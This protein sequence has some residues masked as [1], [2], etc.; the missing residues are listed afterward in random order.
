M[1][2]KLLLSAAIL[3]VTLVVAPT[4]LEAVGGQSI[5]AG[6]FT[7]AQ[8]AT[9]GSQSAPVLGSGRLR[10]GVPVHSTLT[11]SNDGSSAA[12]YLLSARVGGDRGFASHLR[13]V[14]RRRTDHAVLFLGS[15]I[16]LQ[17]ADLGTFRARAAEAF[18]L[19]VTLLPTGST[20]DDNA[21]Q[22]ALGLRRPP[23]DRGRRLEV[24]GALG[25]APRRR[26]EGAEPPRTE[27]YG[28]RS[29]AR[30]STS[31][32]P[33]MSTKLAA[34]ALSGASCRSVR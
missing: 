15:A 29:C 12:R 25:K 34:G 17:T 13:I 7:D 2:R 23:L 1:F 9:H 21:L 16:R 18:D 14:I 5:P 19:T 11:I 8:A 28:R 26:G 20:A 27:P 32:R 6:P 30:G 4:V 31:V 22:G 3:A 33:G 24:G 10:I